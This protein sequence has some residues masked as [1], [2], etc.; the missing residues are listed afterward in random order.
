[1]ALTA[2]INRI[3]Q[4][5]TSIETK[6][7]SLIF[8]T[9]T[10]L[11]RYRANTILAKEPETIAWIESFT[12]NSVFYDV[13]ANIGI[14]SIYAAKA[15]NCRVIAFE[16]S[17]PNLEMLIRNILKNKLQN[18]IT[19]VPVGLSE[20]DSVTKMYFNLSKFTWGGAHNSLGEGL[21]QKGLPMLDANSVQLVAMKLDSIMNL[22][23]LP[24]PNYIKIDVDG[25]ESLVLLGAQET[26]KLVDSVMVEVDPAN[27]K[28]SINVPK[29]LEGAGLVLKEGFAEN[30][31]YVR[32]LGSN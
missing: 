16:P 25:L 5:V 12:P 6:H 24:R 32:K 4:E 7:G 21:N 27:H 22:F 11:P 8:H 9:P 31:L 20:K 19:V 10:W 15:G 17:A 1:M 29:L 28:S 18:L 30:Y 23:N 2:L 14:Y 13:G 3:L 26:L